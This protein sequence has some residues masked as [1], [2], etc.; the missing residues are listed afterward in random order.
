MAQWYCH[1]SGA[2]YGPVPEEALRRWIAEGRVGP[3]DYVWTDGMAAWAVA[4]SL[5]GLFGAQVRAAVAGRT[6]S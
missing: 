1:V 3:G 4:G 2:R 5:P 6:P